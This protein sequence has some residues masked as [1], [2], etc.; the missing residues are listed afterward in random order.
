MVAE[1]S[2]ISDSQPAKMVRFNTIRDAVEQAKRDFS[3][4]LLFL[5]LRSN[6]RRTLPT[7]ILRESTN[8]LKHS[9]L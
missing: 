6:R 5:D 1:D 9:P 4:P 8:C 3:G 7:K 2:D